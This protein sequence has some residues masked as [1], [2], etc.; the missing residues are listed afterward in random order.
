MMRSGQQA[1]EAKRHCGCLGGLSMN[2]SI[3]QELHTE[4]QFAVLDLSG[5]RRTVL[6][7]TSMDTDVPGRLDN[8]DKVERGVITFL[9]QFTEMC[10]AFYTK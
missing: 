10:E 2:L 5:Q 3:C 1:A 8:M 7:T 4:L 9:G 6:S